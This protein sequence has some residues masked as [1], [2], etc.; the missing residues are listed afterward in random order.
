MAMKKMELIQRFVDIINT[1]KNQKIQE[2]REKIGMIKLSSGRI[3]I[4]DK[5]DEEKILKYNWCISEKG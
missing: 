2:A 5:E 3:I 1:V 4:F